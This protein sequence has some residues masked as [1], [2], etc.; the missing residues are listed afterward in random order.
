MKNLE[1]TLSQINDIPSNEGNLITDTH[2]VLR[3]DTNPSK[4]EIYDITHSEFSEPEP[5]I[6]STD[7]EEILNYLHSH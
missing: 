7:P 2:V 6:L 1:I 3:Y 5:M 4:W